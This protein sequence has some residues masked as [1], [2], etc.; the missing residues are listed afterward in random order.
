[1]IRFIFL[2]GCKLVVECFGLRKL[3]RRSGEIIIRGR[4]QPRWV[5]YS[6]SQTIIDLE[7]ASAAVARASGEGATL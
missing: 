6:V 3:D 4:G 5:E 7:N 2:F 1:M